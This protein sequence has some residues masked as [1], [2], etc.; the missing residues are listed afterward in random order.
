MTQTLTIA[1]L[2]QFSDA[3]YGSDGV[4]SPSGT[5]TVG[6]WLL[7]NANFPTLVSKAA[8]GFV[9]QVWENQTT[10]EVVIAY[11]GT[12]PSNY[13]TLEQD[14]YIAAGK[15][16]PGATD[17]AAL[18]LQVQA[19]LPAGYSLA[20]TGHSLGG[21]EA[22]YALTQLVDHGTGAGSPYATV[23]DAPGLS[24]TVI[25]GLHHAPTYY[26]SVN[27]YAQGDAIHAAGIG[28]VQL[29]QLPAV[30]LSGVGPSISSEF[31]QAGAA[32]RLGLLGGLG[33]A[34]AAAAATLLYN[35]AVPAH[36]LNAILS[37]LGG[38]NG[39]NPTGNNVTIGNET[40]GGYLSANGATPPD[41]NLSDAA[42]GATVIGDGTGSSLTVQVPNS[43]GA[44]LTSV[45]GVSGDGVLVPAADQSALQAQVAA[46]GSE[47]ATSQALATGVIAPLESASRIYITESVTST[48]AIDATM[49]TTPLGSGTDGPGQ[50]T[51]PN[52][53]TNGRFEYGLPA[54]GQTATETIVGENNQ[55]TVWVNNGQTYTQL[56]GGAASSVALDTWVDASGT[57]YVFS[58]T[59]GSST[60]S[61]TITNGILG[62]N[63]EN[64]I[65][66]DN[67]NLA[68]AQTASGY[69][70][71][72]LPETLTLNASANAGVDPPAPNFLQGS[73]QSY[74]ISVDAPSTTA[75]TITVTM[76]GAIPSDFEASV[77]D[78]IE[79][80]NS[81]GTFNVTLAA[82]ETNVAFTLTDVTADNGS[83][84]IASGASL[85]LS[86]SLPNP[87]TL[88]GGTIPASP[89]T[90]SYVPEASDT[91]PA[92]QPSN[93]VTGIY[94]S[95]TGI[96]TYTGDG[97]D[98]YITGTGTANLINAQ[99][100]GNDSIVG[101]S[102]ANTINGGSGNSVI[103]LT[104]TSD[105]VNLG[106]GFNTVSGG[107]G[108]D[109][110]DE[111]G[112]D[113]L[114][115]GNG[116]TDLIILGNGSSQIYAG[117]QASLATAIAAGS[118]GTATGT[119]GDFIAVG[120]GSNTIVGGS[121][122]DLIDVGS[123]S[124]VIV[125]G[126]GNDTF[127][128]G[129][130]ITQATTAWAATITQPAGTTG[131]TISQTGV[132]GYYENFTGTFPQPYNGIVPASAT[133]DTVYGGR[134]N[135]FIALGNGNNYVETGNGNDTVLGGMGDDTIIAGSG[136]D[137]IRGGGGAT[138]IEGGS[139]SDTIQGGDGNNTIIGGFGNSTLD[140]ASGPAGTLAFAGA[141]LEQNYVTGGSGN[142][143][144]Y[145]SNGS[146]T[147]IAGTGNTTIYGQAGNENITGGSGNDFLVGGSG[148]DTIA[149]GG[150]GRD[151]LYA[152]GSSSSTSILYGGGGVDV[153]SGGS[154]TNTLYAGDG[155]T[156]SGA[157]SVFASQTDA[158]ASTTIY[159]G[160]GVDLL[161]GGAGS[162]VIYGGGG[163]TSAAPTSILASFGSSTLVGG[164]GTDFI[165][166]GAGTDVLY[167]GDGGTAA[168]PTTGVSG[169]GVSTLNGGAGP[170][171]LQ[172]IASG[173]DLIVSGS[174]NDTMI[175]VGSDTLVAGAGN[176]LMQA[177]AG[178]VNVEVNAG[179]G[180]DTILAHGGTA[181][182][183]LGAGILA[184]D[185]T[186]S[187][188]FDDSGN[189]YLTLSGDGGSIDIEN[190]L[191]GVLVGAAYADPST[192]PL[193]TLL[194]DVLGGDQTVAGPDGDNFMINLALRRRLPSSGFHSPTGHRSTGF[195]DQLD[196]CHGLRSRS[197]Q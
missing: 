80:L 179:F 162:I 189:S 156:A 75:Q 91:A 45:S 111:G 138:Y 51:I 128:G 123:G 36:S 5:G 6:T 129:I 38:P 30:S 89:I 67:F 182:L 102:Q 86:A 161:E 84:D 159:G 175:G 54:T 24:A 81:N 146:D 170:S 37:S 15:L 3:V 116:G 195:Q 73:S 178:S 108:H 83:S 20:V 23:F 131:Y 62:S 130:E 41:P 154:G 113:N 187:V 147:L 64:S 103:T 43:S 44:V 18:A 4:G 82:G 188:S 101:G 69:L 176:D 193:V 166:G 126:P 191:T 12:V 145:G 165:Q 48:G 122:N 60:G 87:D 183:L 144:I 141:S 118:S 58:S 16:A 148:N 196:P 40:E 125:M 186:G 100:S 181:N 160:L 29:G 171:L 72:V 134:G 121:G 139:G 21:Y 33:V 55:D 13:A 151:S 107:S 109:I 27:F 168:T 169:T 153:I 174:A 10:Q 65:T 135:D 124:D 2:S 93:V 190:A 110:I 96:T 32:F 57:Q 150:S 180:N 112:G 119:Q 35:W 49:G 71:I 105:T 142:D 98:D 56:R 120:D 8:D 79:Q 39:T 132:A 158:T 136:T 173:Q 70:G 77:G 59:A 61:L 157:T 68:T 31:S 117:A 184:T 149:A 177:N 1:Q 167:A 52:A 53:S 88:A 152:N 9:A 66:I 194:T 95:G 155:G 74:T 192:I 104:G 137:N 97:A 14:A 90:F 46:D 50:L 115:T 19:S 28:A 25:A 11:R 47:S 185:L 63:T 92:P 22:Q 17:A 78:T 34:I 140:A 163:G 164:L 143:V 133:D 99:N 197:R 106:S 76:S 114:V 42:N 85:E 7:M 127:E 94:N 26:S 172:D